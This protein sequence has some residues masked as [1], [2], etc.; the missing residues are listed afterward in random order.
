MQHKLKYI[1]PSTPIE[2]LVEAGI[3]PEWMWQDIEPHGMSEAENIL[4]EWDWEW[5]W[6]IG[7]GYNEYQ[8]NE[9]AHVRAIISEGIK[10]YDANPKLKQEATEKKGLVMRREALRNEYHAKLRN[11]FQPD[12]I[13]MV[14]EYILKNGEPPYFSLIY[15]YIHSDIRTDRQKI[16]LLMA[17]ALDG[18]PRTPK[19]VFEMLKSCNLP[20]GIS[21]SEQF[22]LRSLQRWSKKPF[23]PVG[24]LSEYLNA[25]SQKL[26]IAKSDS[27]TSLNQAIKSMVDIELSDSSLGGMNL[28]ALLYCLKYFLNDESFQ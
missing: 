9:L 11:N 24:Q 5:G 17:G 21:I 10:A 20:E 12:K 3:V 18:K 7:D 13:E 4:C 14:V 6:D 23:K 28:E 26:S 27:H 19:E 22:P 8:R 2:E 15:G 16:R 25:I 1:S